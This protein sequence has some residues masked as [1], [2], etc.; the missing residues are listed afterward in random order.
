MPFYDFFL[1]PYLLWTLK[2]EEQNDGLQDG[3]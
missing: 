2:K 1:F 3:I